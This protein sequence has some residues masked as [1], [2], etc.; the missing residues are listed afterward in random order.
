MTQSALYIPGIFVS[1]DCKNFAALQ[2][3]F[4][5]HGINLK[6]LDFSEIYTEKLA[7]DPF[8]EKTAKAIKHKHYDI[9]VTYSLGFNFLM[10]ALQIAGTQHAPE[11]LVFLS[12]VG[13]PEKSSFGKQAKTW[14]QTGIH[15]TRENHYYDKGCDMPYSYYE[16]KLRHFQ[17]NTVDLTGH[18]MLAVLAKKDGIVSYDIEEEVAKIGATKVIYLGSDHSFVEVARTLPDEINTHLPKP[19]WI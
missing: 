14:K 13:N 4:K 16:E 6:F 19:L 5:K 3:G 2:G 10:D 18:N 11:T 1:P 9:A 12:P 17:G 7:Y 8:A 15:H